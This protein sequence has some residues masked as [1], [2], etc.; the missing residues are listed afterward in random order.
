MRGY[1]AA[2]ASRAVAKTASRCSSDD[3]WKRGCLCNDRAATRSTFP[4]NGSSPPDYSWTPSGRSPSCPQRSARLHRSVWRDL[5]WENPPQE[6]SRQARN[7][8][9]RQFDKRGHWRHC[10]RGMSLDEVYPESDVST[11]CAR[12]DE[13]REWRQCTPEMS[14]LRSDAL[15]T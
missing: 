4:P 12:H 1:H 11:D 6:I 3:W 13:R 7:D 14:R 8:E 2:S 5:A 10:E 9:R 15:L